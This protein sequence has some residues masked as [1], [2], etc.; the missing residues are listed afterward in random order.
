MK[1]LLNRVAAYLADY[2]HDTDGMVDDLRA[3][4]ERCEEPVAWRYEQSEHPSGDLRGRRWHT[5]FSVHK[6]N[7][8]SWVQ[9]ITPLYLAP[10]AQPEELAKLRA[11]LSRYR[12]EVQDRYDVI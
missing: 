3:A 4:A 5:I 9:N 6:P 10:P 11:Q 2:T 1:E 12:E 8:L 7:T